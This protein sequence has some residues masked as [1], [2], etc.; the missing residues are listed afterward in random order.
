MLCR[1]ASNQTMLHK[2]MLT[3]LTR[4]NT[5]WIFMFLK[6]N[7]IY[8]PSPSHTNQVHEKVAVKNV[9]V[10]LTAFIRIKEFAVFLPRTL[11][12][13]KRCL[14]CFLP[15][16]FSYIFVRARRAA[17]NSHSAR[18]ARKELKSFIGTFNLCQKIRFMYTF[19]GCSS[20]YWSHIYTFYVACALRQVRAQRPG[21]HEFVSLL[22]IYIHH[23]VTH[24]M[25]F[26][27]PSRSFLPICAGTTHGLL[28]CK[29]WEIDS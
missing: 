7:N 11:T 13:R 2:H 1:Y 25:V 19:T 8:T 5:T 24:T 28:Y 16:A 17:R 23:R 9:Q 15:P 10:A 27:T 3:F 12:W 6:L 18:G 26:F 4:N 21:A 29:T 20:L 14:R 22:C